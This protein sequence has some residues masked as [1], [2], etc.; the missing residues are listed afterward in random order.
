MTTKHR[1]MVASS[2]IY[3]ES[4]A[5]YARMG[6]RNRWVHGFVAALTRLGSGLR[7]LDLLFTRTP[8]SDDELASLARSWERD[9]VELV[10]CPGTDSALRV[11]AVLDQLPML[12]FGAHPEN[13]GLELL[14]RRNVSGVRLN[15]PL[16]W[17]FDNF[18]LLKEVI[19]SLERLYVPLNLAS[20]FGFPNVKANYRAHRRREPG[21]W[22]D[23]HSSGAGYRSLTFL[24]DRVGMTSFEGPYETPDEL[25]KGLA[26]L[27][28]RGAAL[29]G[30]NDT[31]LEETATEMLLR[32]SMA[33]ELPL[34]WV[35]NPGV[36]ERCGV[37]DFSSDFEGVGR[38]LGR[39]THGMLFGDL[40][41]D[42]IPFQEDPGE[43][44][45][46]NAGRARSL[47]FDP[48]PAT[49][50]KFEEVLP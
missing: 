50:A 10:I 18:A 36:I 29:V 21:F 39:L 19:P 2:Y 25:E 26:S 40:T 28:K 34:F 47:G 49:C 4:S 15:L 13:N 32:F 5:P 22:I 38:V 24:C 7:D 17:S 45:L 48:S 33:H 46:L 16:M 37:A 14:D 20:Q 23:G 27:D 8:A 41:I 3:G 9:G 11:A 35:N 6:R 44:R 30:F 12:Y 43:R 42:A 31:I 1:V